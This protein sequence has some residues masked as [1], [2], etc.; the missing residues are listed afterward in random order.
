[1]SKTSQKILMVVG[2]CML[3][4]GIILI[5]ISFSRFGGFSFDFSSFGSMAFSMFGGVI[6]IGLGIF[7]LICGAISMVIFDD[8]G[9]SS[10]KS[11][12]IPS[13]AENPYRAKK[14]DKN[15]NIINTKKICE[16]CNAELSTEEK[17]CSNCGSEI[18]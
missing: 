10:Y 14:A 8:T 3:V 15:K 2:A 11:S 17:F 4:G 1:M 6:L 12:T 13:A 16:F 18:K 5:S 7:M 9:N